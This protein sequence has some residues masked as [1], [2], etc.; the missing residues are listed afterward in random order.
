MIYCNPVICK[1]P[2]KKDRVYVLAKD[3]IKRFCE[4]YKISFEDINEYNRARFYLDKRQMLMKILK[5]NTRLTL[6][7]IGEL[8]NGRDHTTVMHSVRKVDDL[9]FT[10]PTYNKEFIEVQ[11]HVL[12]IIPA[13]NNRP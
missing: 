3:V 2:T 6:K 5:D 1:L 13:L 7:Q 9:C 11:L 8:L 4:F 12:Q 10:D